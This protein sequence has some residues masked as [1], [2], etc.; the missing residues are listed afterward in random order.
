MKKYDINDSTSYILGISLIIEALKEIPNKVKKVYLSSKA[1][2][3]KEL[4][5]LVSL[6]KKNN[7]LI[8]NDDKTIDSLSLKENC[9][10]IAVFDK[11]EFKLTTNKHLVLYRFDLEGDIGTILRS[12]VSFDFKDI[13]LIDSNI[14]LFNPK[15]IRASMGSFFHLNIKQYNSFDDYFKEFKYNKYPFVSKGK[16]ELSNII[17]KEPYSII[18]SNN[19][20]NIE[21]AFKDVYYVKHK[22]DDDLSL[23]SLSSIVLNYAYH[24]SVCDT[25]SVCKD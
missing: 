21:D 6:C 2:K 7:I 4:D 9:Y 10:G 5:K 1:N 8:I 14:D 16:Y 13:V 23:T 11:Y 24:Q 17:F 20:S 15:L 18:I 22:N 25:N 19:N 12:A 3:N